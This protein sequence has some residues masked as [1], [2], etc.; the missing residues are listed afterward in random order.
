MQAVVVLEL[1]WALAAA[2]LVVM[3]EEVARLSVVF[4][5]LWSLRWVLWSL[6]M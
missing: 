1:C 3:L 6:T 4:C 2:V 5:G